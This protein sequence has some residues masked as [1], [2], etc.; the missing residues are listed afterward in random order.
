MM[1][2]L[3]S[4]KTIAWLTSAQMVEVDRAMI[5][6]FQIELIQ[7]MEATGR[8]MARI[9]RERFLGGRPPLMSGFGHRSLAWH[10]V[11]SIRPL[12]SAK[13]APARWEAI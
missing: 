9:S 2:R 6:D 10:D 7:M 1:H 11:Q 5:E 12:P 8:A 3:T 4:V 13:T